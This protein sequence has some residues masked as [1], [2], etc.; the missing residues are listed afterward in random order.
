TAPGETGDFRFKAEF[1]SKALPVHRP[2]SHDAR[3]T[4]PADSP[5]PGCPC[6]HAPRRGGPRRSCW[7]EDDAPCGVRG[8]DRSEKPAQGHAMS[9]AEP[10]W[11]P[12]EEAGEEEPPRRLRRRTDGPARRSA[13]S[14]P[15]EGAAAGLADAARAYQDFRRQPDAGDLDA[16]CATRNIPT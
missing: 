11:S 8:G 9:T 16:W 15:A 2:G 13:P 3:A 5:D 12:I 6:L 1:P 10:E 4:A 7:G 14:A